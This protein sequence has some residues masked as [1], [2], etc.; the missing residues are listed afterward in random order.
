MMIDSLKR[1]PQF[2]MTFLSIGI[3]LGLASW[4]N[5]TKAFGAGPQW[6]EGFAE[7]E[8]H[9]NA[10]RA[11]PSRDFRGMARGYM[12]AG[13]WAPGQMKDNAVSWKTAVVPAKQVT[14]FAF[15]GACSPLPEEFARG[16]EAKLSVNGR[17]VLTFTL[18]FTRD[19]TWKEGAYQ[20]K[21]LS[22]RVEYPYTVS[23]RQFDLHGNS[24]IYELTVPADAVEAG[25]PVVLKVEILPFERW[26]RSWFAV[27]E[28]R[29]VLKQSM[30]SLRG[31]ID[32]LRRDMADLSEQAHVLATKLYAPEMESNKYVHSTVYQNGYRHLHP[33]DLIPLQNGE[34][35]ITARE[36]TE[37]YARDGDVILLRSKDGGANLG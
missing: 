29:D 12:T 9:H 27:K 3:S 23:H 31:E 20:L 6:V 14:T 5:P 15:V 21:Y 16:P 17:H 10:N 34:I 28:R 33:A 11:M 36:A 19:F 8:T 30:E 13:W 4:T 26:D 22:K 35:L 32:A 7:V 18:G 25:Q 24:G 2:F 37:H 1:N